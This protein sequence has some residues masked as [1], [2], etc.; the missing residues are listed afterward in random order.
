MSNCSIL[1]VY[2]KLECVTNGFVNIMSSMRCYAHSGNYSLRVKTMPLLH[3]LMF[4]A[5]KQVIYIIVCNANISGIHG[6][7]IWHF[8]WIKND[9]YYLYFQVILCL[10][11]T[12]GRL[13]H[14]FDCSV[15]TVQKIWRRYRENHVTNKR[16]R[17][18]RQRA[19]TACEDRR[20]ILRSRQLRFSTLDQ[21][22]ADWT[23]FQPLK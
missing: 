21:L 22:R 4:D 11:A 3:Q 10:I 8:I 15:R 14:L 23:D 1:T 16:S 13:S 7:K 12:N 20:L 19:T 5:A 6:K 17:P 9:N 18:D 2:M